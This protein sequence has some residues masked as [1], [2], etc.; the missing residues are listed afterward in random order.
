MIDRKHYFASLNFKSIGW[1]L[2]FGIIIFVIMIFD[3]NHP[4]V[5]FHEIALFLNYVIASLIISHWL[6]PQYFYS[7]KYI[8]F[9]VLTIFVIGIVIVVEELVLERI[10]FPDVT[11]KD[12]PGIGYT[13]I[14]VLPVIVLLVGF[15]FA[16]DAHRRTLEL[17]QLKNAFTDSQLHFLKSQ[18][19][20]HFL[21]NNLNNLYSFALENSPEMPN[22]ILQLSSLIRYMIYDSQEQKVLLEKEIEFLEDFVNLHKLQIEGRG[23]VIFKKTGNASSKFIAP[24]LLI[25]IVENSFKHSTS[26]QSDSIEILIEIFVNGN[27]LNLFCSNTFTNNQNNHNLSKGIGLKNLRKRLNLI[28]PERHKLKIDIIEG[29]YKV[30]LQ[31][32]LEE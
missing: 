15:K 3:K 27:I 19:D 31:I 5:H 12:F 20:P 11:E 24:L 14:E 30:Q 16:Y 10:F 18:I 29:M 2:V 7:N 17:E 4:H 23:E 32:N 6:L 21:F 13:I 26:S 8:P 25:A 28:Y 9:I 22:M 1:Q